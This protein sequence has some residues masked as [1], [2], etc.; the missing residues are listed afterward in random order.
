MIF[1]VSSIWAKSDARFVS[2]SVGTVMVSLV[3]VVGVGV[4]CI[5]SWRKE[6][7]EIE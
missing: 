1:S 4:S 3:E 5:V 7:G 2:A 6:K